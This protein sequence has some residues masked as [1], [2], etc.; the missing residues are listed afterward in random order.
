K[1]RQNILIP[2][3]TL[4]LTSINKIRQNILI[5]TATLFLTSI[6]KIRQKALIPAAAMFLASI[7]KIR[8]KKALIPAAAMFLASINKIRQ[9]KALIPAAAVFLVCVVVAGFFTSHSFFT[10]ND[11]IHS[12]AKGLPDL[13]GKSADSTR[14]LEKREQP[15]D[16]IIYSLNTM[17]RENSGYVP[18]QELQELQWQIAEKPTVD[19]KKKLFRRAL[20]YQ[21]NGELLKAGGQYLELLKLYPNDIEI[22]NNLGSVYQEL[23]NYNNAVIE[24]RKAIYLNPNYY[25]ARNNLGVVLYKNGD[26][27]AAMKEFKIILGDNPKDVQCITNLGALSK[28]MRHPEM[29]RRFFEEALAIDPAYPEA[30]YNMAI[31]LEKDEVNRAIFHFQKFLDYA[32]SSQHLSRA[33]EVIK[34][35]ESLF[36]RNDHENNT[37]SDGASNL[38]LTKFP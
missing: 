3:A 26:F 17:V 11:P 14:E 8:Q 28:K 4:F 22:H 16:A 5:P 23:G 32:T 6:N 2:T 34:R 33:E 9:K 12:A 27:R 15:E 29:A 1:I 19:V 10:K 35:L 13:H 38:S 20:M 36:G 31:L 7:N 21:N 18:E 37:L 30:H 24:Y 25:T